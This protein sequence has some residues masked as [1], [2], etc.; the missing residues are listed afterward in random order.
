MNILALAFVQVGI[1]ISNVERRRC[2]SA[3]PEASWY[4]YDRPA[5][6]Q[7][8]QTVALHE[9]RWLYLKILSVKDAIKKVVFVL[10]RSHTRVNCKIGVVSFVI[11]VVC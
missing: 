7:Q 1:P 5:A 3:P 9:N 8:S 11:S 4:C 6:Q 2:P 10:T